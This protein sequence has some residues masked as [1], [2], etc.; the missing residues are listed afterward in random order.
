MYYYILFVFFIA[1]VSGQ[2]VCRRIDW[3]TTWI[4]GSLQKALTDYELDAIILRKVARDLEHKEFKPSEM[5]QVF[6]IKENDI[7]DSDRSILGF[8]TP[9]MQV[10]MTVN[11]FE[12]DGLTG[13]VSKTGDI[14]ALDAETIK[15]S[16]TNKGIFSVKFN[17]KFEVT[18]GGDKFATAP[19]ELVEKDI[20]SSWKQAFLGQTRR[21]TVFEDF[22]NKLNDKTTKDI[23]RTVNKAQAATRMEFNRIFEIHLKNTLIQTDFDVSV[24]ACNKEST[25]SWLSCEFWNYIEL[26]T[27]AGSAALAPVFDLI[28]GGK[29][30][31]FD[32]MDV[33]NTLASRVGHIEVKNVEFKPTSVKFDIQKGQDRRDRVMYMIGRYF[34]KN[35]EALSKPI[36]ETIST[37][38]TKSLEPMA[39]IFEKRCRATDKQKKL[40]AATALAMGGAFATGGLGAAAWVGAAAG[41][42]TFKLAHPNPP[43]ATGDSITNM[44]QIPLLL[45]DSEDTL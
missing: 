37:E 19:A 25:A 9:T 31:P 30:Q 7:S 8:L 5:V 20:V 6:Q 12:V 28:F 1:M 29:V 11:N 40:M 24:Y 4:T 45:M 36:E 10:K 43:K 2:D 13:F 21:L 27:S 3:T 17:A 35:V 16:S 42:A 44:E 32:K 15:Y 26:F 23:S 14:E 33:F 38:I 39:D 41:T 18:F 34:S 22:R